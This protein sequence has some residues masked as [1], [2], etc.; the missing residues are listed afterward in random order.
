MS[1]LFV[2]SGDF[3]AL[4][5]QAEL[6]AIN[7][8]GEISEAVAMALKE[9]EMALGEKVT[10]IIKY[11]KNLRSGAEEL[12]RM[13]LEFKARKQAKEKKAVAL[14]NFLKVA[15]I[16]KFEAIEGVV[17]STKSTAVEIDIDAVIPSEYLTV[18]TTETPNKTA[19]KKAIGDG[20]TIEGVQVVER[21]SVKV[22]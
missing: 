4:L 7:A 20:E 3:E 18:K 11:V 19:L 10:N 2:L 15:G 16:T 9:S 17:K 21:L 6:E 5:K 22:K 14:E 1:N 13:E 12:K 8:D